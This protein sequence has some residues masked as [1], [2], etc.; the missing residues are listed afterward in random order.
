MPME[1]HIISA[2]G[3]KIL[4][5]DA[6]GGGNTTLPEHDLVMFKNEG[7]R[8]LWKKRVSGRR[9]RLNN[10]LELGIAKGGSLPYL[11]DLCQAKFIV[12]VDIEK[13]DP[14]IRLA[15][16]RSEMKDQFALCFQT[17]Q[18]DQTALNKIVSEYFPNG[19]DMIVDDASHLLADTRRSFEILFPH[20]RPGGLYVIEDYSWA[21]NKSFY[22]FAPNRYRGQPMTTQLIL[23]ITML[24][25]TH[26][27]WITSVS[28]DNNTITV[29][30]GP[31]KTPKPL[32]IK[33]NTFNWGYIDVQNIA[34]P[35][36]IKDQSSED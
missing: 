16:D 5:R 19:L 34:L 29:E 7:Q 1:I 15:Y 33:D 21:Q 2:C 20:L 22:R 12:G 27:R 26:D 6:V 9:Q 32:S 11:F 17:N 13:E 10:I 14:Q 8:R 30:K 35:D 24:M 31:L 3:L 25:T 23:E 36:Q 4:S 18:T 28:A